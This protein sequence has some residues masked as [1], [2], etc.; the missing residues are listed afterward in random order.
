MLEKLLVG[1]LT[2]QQGKAA[3]EAVKEVALDAGL[4]KYLQQSYGA[5][6]GERMYA[7]AMAAKNFAQ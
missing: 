1:L 7:A 4:K 3:V 5:A 2:K 6:T